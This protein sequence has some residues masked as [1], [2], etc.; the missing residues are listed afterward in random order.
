MM[1]II[2]ENIS[3]LEFSTKNEI[4]YLH[5]LAYTFFVDASNKFTSNLCSDTEKLSNILG[6]KLRS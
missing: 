1:I 2:I 5:F 4:S 3:G 6:V